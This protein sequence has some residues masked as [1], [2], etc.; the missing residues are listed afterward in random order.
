[1]Q[2]RSVSR[3]PRPWYWNTYF[4]FAIS[5]AVIGLLGLVRGPSYILDPGQIKD[6]ENPMDPRLAWIYLGA[7]ILFAVNG[8]VSHTAHLREYR[9]LSR[10][11]AQDEKK[12]A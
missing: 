1:L 3:G 5:L 6:V 7:A 10:Q 12:D 8:Y 2:K 4:L 9:L 11:P